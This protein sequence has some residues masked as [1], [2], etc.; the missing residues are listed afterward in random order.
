MNLGRVEISGGALLAAALLYY[1]DSSGIF[2][3]AFG[4]CVFHELG[5]WL[6]IRALGGR[7]RYLRLSCAGAELRL[8][9]ARLLPPWKMLLAALAGP[10]MNLLLA[11]G[12]SAL[13]RRGAGERLYLFAGLNLGLTLFNLLPAGWLDGGRAL[14]NLL[15]LLGR[16][17]FG[18]R[19]VE[20]C[21]MAVALLLLGTGGIL[22]WESGG[23]NFTLLIAGLWMT[24]AARQGQ[25]G[26]FG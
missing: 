2:L 11:M 9:A 10:G 22:L 21:S 17:E 7:V 14:E 16:E 26:G 23:R 19:S 24:Q 18:R 15:A 4:A 6:A 13:A 25:K 1:L 12:S 8:S 3:W 5:H 20:I